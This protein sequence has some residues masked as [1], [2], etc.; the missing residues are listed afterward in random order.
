MPISIL[1]TF[2]QISWPFN[3]SQGGT[4][5]LVL[6]DPL[7]ESL[8]SATGEP[9]YTGSLREQRGERS[10][11]CYE[12]VSQFNFLARDTERTSLAAAFDHTFSESA[13][14]YSFANYMENEIFLEGAA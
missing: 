2:A 7:C 3:A 10:G 13:E 6:G 1:T 4:D 12:D 9:F 11:T 8:T 5:E 14:F